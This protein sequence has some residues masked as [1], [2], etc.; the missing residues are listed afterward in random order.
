M[1]S[2]IAISPE[3]TAVM[4]IILPTVIFIGTMLGSKLRALSKHAQEQVMSRANFF[5]ESR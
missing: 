4:V 1:V 3:M 5:I 2:L